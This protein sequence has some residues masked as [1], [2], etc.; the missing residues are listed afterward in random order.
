M[1]LPDR[2]R[3]LLLSMHT[4]PVDQ[5]GTG[6]A[7]G[8]NV[9]VWHLAHALAHAGWAVD[10]ATLD[11]DPSHSPGIRTTDLAPG[12]RLLAVALAGAAEVPKE[13]L[14]GFA[15]AF[16]EALAQHYA[17]DAAPVLH[18]HYWLSGVAGL[19]MAHVL[20]APLVLTLHTSAAAKNLRAGSDESP[21]PPEREAAERELIA[22]ACRT[23]VNTP[24][25]QRQVVELYGADPARVVVIPP[26]VDP[27]VFHPPVPDER[28]ERD[29]TPFTVLSAGRM[30]PLKGQQILIRALGALRRSHPDVPVRLLLAGVGSPDF[31]AHLRGLADAEGVASAVDFRGSLPREDLARLMGRVDAVAVASSS[32]TF[33]LVAVEA[34]ACGTPVLAT[35][36]DGL[37]YAVRDGETG[38]LVPDREPAS[39]ADA[40]YRAARDPGAWRAMS[41]A[42]R[43]RARELTWDDVAAQHAAAY[44]ACAVREHDA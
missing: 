31:L 12:V 8:M 26:G 34:Q 11:R 9:Y 37:R 2:P 42:A 32:E 3:V 30:Q 14:P 22:H 24:A 17:D 33:G 40:L 13:R 27:E 10:M 23:V 41:H 15:R 28:D 5:P 6:D 44:L 39:W 7:G 25:E 36:V 4:S 19:H 16:G 43:L 38:R 20:G 35:D 1:S 29:E 21:E 18:A